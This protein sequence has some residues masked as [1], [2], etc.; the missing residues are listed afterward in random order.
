MFVYPELT[1]RCRIYTDVAKITS[2]NIFQVLEEAMTIHM[3]NVDN[4]VL[5]MRYEKGIQPLVR[6]KIIRKEVNIKV[7]DN[8][9]TRL[10]SSSLVMYGGSQ[11]HM[12]SVEI[13]I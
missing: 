10:Q 11:L 12:F 7:S 4:M 5:L 8:L 6:K 2:E 1:G 13:R 3:K 9:A